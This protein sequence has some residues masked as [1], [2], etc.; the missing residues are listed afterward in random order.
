VAY[1]QGQSD[2]VDALIV[3]DVALVVIALLVPLLRT[4]RIRKSYKRLFPPNR[5]D[6]NWYID[7]DNERIL[8]TVPGIGEGK[9]LWT[10]ILSFAQ[11]RKITMF[12]ITEVQY[13]PIPTNALS[14]EQRTE[15]DELVA[16]NVVRKQK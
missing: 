9:Y 14:P 15:L 16:R 10:G 11:D 4:Y 1:I 5:S 2:L 13:L 7:I 6:R 12:Y 8:S 3:P